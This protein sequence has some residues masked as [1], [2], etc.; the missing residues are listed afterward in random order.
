[1]RSSNGVLGLIVLAL[2]LVVMSSCEGDDGCPG[3]DEY[4]HLQCQEMRP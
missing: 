3:T 4:S 2:F 1:M